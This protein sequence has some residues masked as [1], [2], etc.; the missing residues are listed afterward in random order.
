V[1][2]AGAPSAGDENAQQVGHVSRR[3][4]RRRH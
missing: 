4:M 2:H 1:H 3:A